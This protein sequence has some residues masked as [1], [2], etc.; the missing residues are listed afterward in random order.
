MDFDLREEHVL[1]QKAIRNF[2]QKV[3]APLVDDAE[4][5]NVFPKQL[6]KKMGALGY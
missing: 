4:E 3:I 5:T 2:A 6:F 1:F